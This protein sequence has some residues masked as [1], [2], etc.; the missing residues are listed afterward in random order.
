MKKIVLWM[1]GISLILSSC[2]DTSDIEKQRDEQL[3]IL[4]NYLA[5]KNI[6]YAG[7]DTVY[8]LYLDTTLRDSTSI[9]IKGSYY[10]KI[11]YNLRLVDDENLVETNNHKL[12][13][14]AKLKPV[15]FF[16][17]PVLIAVNYS[18]IYGIYRS[19]L[20]LKKNDTAEFVIPYDWAFGSNYT[21]LIPAFAS[22]IF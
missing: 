6:T 17:G 2:L 22:L 1:M 20:Q 8:R 3:Q 5:S 19:L 14:I 11:N 16:P 18:S 15:N 12:A 13:K 21:S 7:T 4:K 10:V 9:P